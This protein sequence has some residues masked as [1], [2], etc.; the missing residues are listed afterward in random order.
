MRKKNEEARCNNCPYF[1]GVLVN[2]VG[3]CLRFPAI[4]IIPYRNGIKGV[5][6]ENWSKPWTMTDYT[7]GEH[8]DFF[9][10]EV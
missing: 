8:P 6:V 2:D 3:K 9:H 4:L 10:V 7:C 5:A 1:T